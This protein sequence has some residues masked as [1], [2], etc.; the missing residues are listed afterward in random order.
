M[1]VE[2]ADLDS[3]TAKT[4]DITG[5]SD[6]PHSVTITPAQFASLKMTGSLM[7]TSTLDSGHPHSIRVR[8]TS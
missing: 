4:Y 6:H 2:P 1:I 8:C 5:A 3:Q 7:V